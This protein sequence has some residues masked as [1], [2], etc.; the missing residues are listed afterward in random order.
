MADDDVVHTTG[1]FYRC[2]QGHEFDRVMGNDPKIALPWTPT[3]PCPTC[4]QAGA[5]QYVT[6]T[7]KPLAKCQFGQCAIAPPAQ[8]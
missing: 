8:S 6:V 4:G 1:R 5:T 3:K 2:P 7:H